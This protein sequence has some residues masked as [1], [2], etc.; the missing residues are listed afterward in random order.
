MTAQRFLE[1][2]DRVDEDLLGR[3]ETV[4]VTPKKKWRKWVAAAACLLLAVGIGLSVPTVLNWINSELP[5]GTETKLPTDADN[6]L[7][8]PNLGGRPDLE[9]GVWNGWQM[10]YVLSSDLDR[11]EPDQYIAIKVGYGGFN[12]LNH[13]VYEGRT[14]YDME[15][16]LDLVDSEFGKLNALLTDGPYLKYGERIYTTGAPDGTVWTEEKYNKKVAHYGETLLSRYIVDGE[17]LT[18]ELEAACESAKEKMDALRTVCEQAEQA[19][20]QSCEGWDI[21]QGRDAFTE[22]GVCAIVK[23]EKLYIFVQKEQLIALEIEDKCNYH[24]SYASRRAFEGICQSVPE[25]DT[26]VSG[27]SLEKITFE[28]YRSGIGKAD[29]DQALIEGITELM[30]VYGDH[31]RITFYSNKTMKETFFADMNYETIN[32]FPKIKKSS[33]TWLTVKHQNFSFA[34][35]KEISN[36]ENITSIHIALGDD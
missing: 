31:L 26:A 15:R 9:D 34:A 28:I 33:M 19:Y 35:L 5:V 27:F 13:F 29:S 4:R 1:L 18:D 23:N 3:A 10:E 24:F 16:E 30:K 25:L 32:I 7:W 20:R 2:M 11:M 12:G 36:C 21:Y 6:I 22:V 8:F 14:Y 17:L